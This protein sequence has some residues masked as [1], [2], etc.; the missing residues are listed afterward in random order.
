MLKDPSSEQGP[1]QD[2]APRPCAFYHASM[3]TAPKMPRD[4]A[5]GVDG[6]ATSGLSHRCILNPG[7]SSGPDGEEIGPL[8]CTPARQVL[9]QA[10]RRMKIARLHATLPVSRAAEAIRT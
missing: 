10:H 6:C 7:R 9:C 5:R 3:P 2:I 4:F 8:A 1:S